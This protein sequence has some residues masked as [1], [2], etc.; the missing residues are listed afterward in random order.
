MHDAL[1]H[2]HAGEVERA[3]AFEA[4]GVHAQ[5][6]RV[7]T[8]AVVGVDAAAAAE[9]VLRR[10]GVELVEL[11]VLGP[12]GDLQVAAPGGHRHRASH[13]A[14]R[15]VAAPRA[16]QALRQLHPETHRAA[17]AGAVAELGLGLTL[18]HGLAGGPRAGL[19]QARRLWRVGWSRA[20]D[21]RPAGRRTRARGTASVR[22]TG[23]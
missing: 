3:H 23:E 2:R 20:T 21:A 7:R 12:G 14:E 1:Q 9:V 19:R 6:V 5:L 11:Q 16:G 10:Q 15:A 13:A 8:P 17:V 18:A 22:E 4:G